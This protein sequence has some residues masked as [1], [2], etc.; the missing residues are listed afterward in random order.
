MHGVEDTIG[1]RTS[2]REPEQDPTPESLF[3][4]QYVRLSRTAMLLVDSPQ[5]AEEIVQDAFAE[6]VARWDRVDHA[7]AIPYLYRSVVNGGRASLRRLRTARAHV[8][9]TPGPG[10]NAESELLRRARDEQIRA[11]VMKLPRRQRQVIVLRFFSDLSLSDVAEALNI[12]P[13]AVAVATQHALRTLRSVGQEF[14]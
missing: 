11:A 7:K 12:R 3:R 5:L 10:L 6:L 14:L 2:E 9:D 4:Q 13:T 8:P 1:G